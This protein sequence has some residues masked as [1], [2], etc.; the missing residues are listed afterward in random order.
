MCQWEDLTLEETFTLTPDLKLQIND[1]IIPGGKANKLNLEN[2][3]IVIMV[4]SAFEDHR[5]R[6]SPLVQ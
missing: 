2:T 3:D 4:N 6:D 5:Y 1:I